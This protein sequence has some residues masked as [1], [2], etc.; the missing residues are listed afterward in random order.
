MKRQFS[1]ITFALAATLFLSV[2]SQILAQ[3]NVSFAVL[4]H[5]EFGASS[6]QKQIRVLSSQQAYAAALAEYTNETPLQIDFSVGR[7]LLVD[8][9]VR[10]TGG[11]SI[12]VTSVEELRKGA[13]DARVRLTRPGRTCITAQA[14]TSPYQF[15]YIPTRMEILI[16]EELYTIDCDAWPKV[17]MSE[18]T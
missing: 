18:P 10:L 4:H 17:E 8:M 6:S 15:V 3:S 14:L 7:V 11:F 16:S 1:L 12:E 5:G 2:E 13:V 9:G